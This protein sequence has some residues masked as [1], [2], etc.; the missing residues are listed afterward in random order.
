VDAGARPRECRGLDPVEITENLTP[1]SPMLKEA[2]KRLANGL[3]PKKVLAERYKDQQLKEVA[4]WESK[5]RP[6]PPPHIIKQRIV[7][8]CGT[9]YSCSVLVETG[10][11]KGEM[12]EAQKSNYKKVFSIELGTDLY[13]QAK[14]RFKNDA[15]VTLLQGDSGKVLAKVIDQINEPAV[16]WLDGHYS[17]G[18]TAK[19]QKDCPIY[20]ELNCIFAKRGLNHVLLIDDARLFVGTNDYP[21]IKELTAYIQAFNPSY[22]VEVKDDVIHA[23]SG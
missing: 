11:Y 2:I 8:D 17:G 12:V 19:G 14:R 18:V 4:E 16:F 15:N 9:R 10:T 7:K 23:I 1:S 22:T 13:E 5:G 20:E 21:S 3:M 6:A